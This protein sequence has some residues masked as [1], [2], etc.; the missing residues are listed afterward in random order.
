MTWGETRC[1]VVVAAEK[2]EG[3]TIE[4]EPS[5]AACETLTDT[6]APAAPKEL[7]AISSEGAINLIWDPNTERDLGGYLVFRGVDPA[8]TLQQITETPVVE[9]S[10]RDAVQ[11][12][13]AFVYAVK[14][15]DKAGNQSGFS[16]RVVETAR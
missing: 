16:P 3:T 6:F 12:G 5:P 7:K 15:V 10:F 14:A 1:Y 2:I 13:V 11:A 8:E 4:S 9:P